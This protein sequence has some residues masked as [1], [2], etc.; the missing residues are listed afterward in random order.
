MRCSCIPKAS[1]YRKTIRIINL[2]VA[3]EC[4]NGK[5][6]EGLKMSHTNQSIKNF[7]DDSDFKL[8]T[9]VAILNLVINEIEQLNNES[10][11]ANRDKSEGL[12]IYFCETANNRLDNLYLVLLEMQS[13][14]QQINEEIRIYAGN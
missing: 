9:L 4:L 6:S 10:I 5:K 2:I 1:L 12:Q 13:S 7:L 11:S 8:K 3:W 14:L